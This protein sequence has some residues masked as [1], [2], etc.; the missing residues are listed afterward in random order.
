MAGDDFFR[1]AC[2]LG[3]PSL[4]SR[5]PALLVA[6][7][8]NDISTVPFPLHLCPSIVISFNSTFPMFR[9]LSS[10]IDLMEILLG[11]PSVL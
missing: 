1:A 11:Q 8:T 3:K 4:S 2:A 5:L 6:S 7:E 9:S 10:A